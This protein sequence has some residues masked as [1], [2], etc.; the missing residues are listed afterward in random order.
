MS[1]DMV[2][3][4][5]HK[6]ST[7]N[8]LRDEI[9][10]VLSRYDV[11]S[12]LYDKDA[13]I[14]ALCVVAVDKIETDR[15]KEL[16]ADLDDKEAECRYLRGELNVTKAKLAKAVEA[17]LDSGASLAAAISLLENNGKKA[18][19][20]NKMF[21]MMLV[22]YRNSLERTRTIYAELKGQTK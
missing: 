7:A 22:D 18:A 9:N 11:D 1:D 2:K 17:M 14:D 6:L 4:H 16:E 8:W 15:I 3:R 10:E 13:S 12:D 21:E 19:P 5:K 20:S